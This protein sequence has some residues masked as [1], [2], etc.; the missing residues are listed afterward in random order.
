LQVDAPG[1]RQSRGESFELNQN[2][3]VHENIELIP[4]KTAWYDF[5]W[6]WWVVVIMLG[7]ILLAL[8]ILIRRVKNNN[9]NN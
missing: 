8:F 4:L 2:Q 9:K 7:M 1:Y 6:K 5:D 3:A